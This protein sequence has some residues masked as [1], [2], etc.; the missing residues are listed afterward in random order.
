MTWTEL[1]I[2]VPSEYAEPVSHL[3]SRHGEGAAVV[4]MPG[5]FN[6]DE[7]EAAPIGGPVVVRTYLPEDA[8]AAG[9][10]MMIDVGLR[11]IAYL[12]PLPDLAVR[13]VDDEEWKDQR[14]EPIRVGRHLV[15]AP[16]GSTLD[17]GPGDIAIPLEPGL[18]F[19]T[20]HHPTTAMVLSAMEDVAIDGATV[21]DAG[22]GSGILSIAAIMLGAKH[23]IAFDVEDDSIRSTTQNVARADVSSQITVVHG[24]LPDDRI[25]PHAFDFV[26]ANISANVLKLLSSHLLATLNE[27]GFI[28]ASGVLEERY[29]EVKVAFRDAGGSL[30]D[31]RITG[32]W[33]CFKVQQE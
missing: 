19:G 13:R 22:C 17:L 21:L 26:F 20:G 10:M 6:P 25:D 8:T 15:I 12:C 23:A 4:E 27:G 7:G 11:L 24:S 18:A 32:D 30:F 31:K 33:T 1:S 2:E 16:P 14:F 9:R 28:I 3:F 5:G 29:A